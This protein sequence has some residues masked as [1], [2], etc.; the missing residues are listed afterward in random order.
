MAKNSKARRDSK[1]KQEQK[2]LNMKKTN[3]EESRSKG[4]VIT[5][6]D[7]NSNDRELKQAFDKLFGGFFGTDTS[8]NL[9]HL[10]KEISQHQRNYIHI[11][12]QIIESIGELDKNDT[13]GTR[14]EFEGKSLDKFNNEMKIL[15]RKEITVKSKKVKIPKR[16]IGLYGNSISVNDIIAL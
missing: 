13:S 16:N 2:K 10:K 9:M 5:Y 3:E 12:K 15:K 11:R 6:D 1:K 14:F 7:I 8:F 4:V